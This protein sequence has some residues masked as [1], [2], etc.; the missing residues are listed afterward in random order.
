MM[1]KERGTR[2][3]VSGGGARPGPEATVSCGQGSNA[4]FLLESAANRASFS[5]GF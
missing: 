1:E 2:S 4:A 5:A 3:G